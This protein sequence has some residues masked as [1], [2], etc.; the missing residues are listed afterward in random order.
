MSTQKIRP[1]VAAIYCEVTEILSG[2]DFAFLMNF[3]GLT[4]GQFSDLRKQL[5]PKGAKA[6]VIKNALIAKIAADLGWDDISSILSGPTAVITGNGDVADIAKTLVDFVSKIEAVSIKGGQLNKKVIT[7]VEVTQL[8]EL[9]SLASQQARLLGT[10][11]A[12][13]SQMARVLQAKIDLE[14]SEAP[15]T[16]EAAPTVEE[17]VPVVEEV[18]PATTPDGTPA[19]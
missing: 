12:P 8:S 15:A 16:E 6:V 7:E 2:K 5:A 1:E 18:A 19:A 4:V 10:L 14:G 3:G 9:I 13:A 11:Q 17:T